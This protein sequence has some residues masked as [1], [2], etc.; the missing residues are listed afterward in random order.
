MIPWF[1]RLFLYLIVS[2]LF[3]GSAAAHEIRPTVVTATFDGTG[4]YEIEL[5]A[6]LE[7]LLAGIGP[8]HQ[9]TDDA[10][11]ALQYKS[12]RALP[13]PELQS[14][15]M[16]FAQEWLKG[17]EIIFDGTRVR[18]EIAAIEVPPVGDPAFARISIVRLVGQAPAGTRDLVWRYAPAF[19]SS[20]L[21]VTPPGDE[22]PQ[23]QWLKDGAPSKPFTI[24]AAVSQSTFE[25]L[26]AYM[27]LGFIHI[28]PEGLDHILFVL[29]LYLLSTRLQPLLLQVTAFTL[30]HSITLALGLYG[31]VRISPEIVEPL[32]AASIAY[33]AIENMMTT[34][35]HAWRP[36]IVFGFGLLHGLGFAGVLQEIG[37]PR[38]EYVAGLVGF[39]VGVELGQLSVIGLAWLATG[40]WY[41]RRPWYRARVVLPASGL[42]AL[43]GL[44][45]TAERLFF[46]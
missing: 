15:F 38:E 4:S 31:I 43:T 35:L 27:G 20:I 30:A 25:L 37:L 40:L 19:G 28:L 44:Y 2:L 5:K 6:N 3:S 46:A 9:D 45:W 32:I 12:L 29:G 34:R 39:N 22:K 23:T 26:Y 18:P 17:V 11:S 1:S 13:A 16:A 42:I 10:P 7:I 36:F 24:N 14:R 8:E 21:R 41:R 33:V